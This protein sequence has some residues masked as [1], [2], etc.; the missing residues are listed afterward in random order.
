MW[1]NAAVTVKENVA[2]TFL[3]MHVEHIYVKTCKDVAVLQPHVKCF[4]SSLFVQS[5]RFDASDLIWV[6]SPHYTASDLSV[7]EIG[8][9]L[10]VRR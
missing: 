2:K 1:P 9:A 7:L 6:I 4:V 10:E 5:E 3:R 8:P